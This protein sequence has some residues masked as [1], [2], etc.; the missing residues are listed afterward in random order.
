MSSQM[1]Y[2]PS[3]AK[4]TAAAVPR[5]QAKS[6]MLENAWIAVERACF[7]WTKVIIPRPSWQGLL[8]AWVY[9]YVCALNKST[10]KSSFQVPS[11][12]L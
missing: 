5:L 2:G 6:L 11:S 10:Q 3:G 9:Q 8:M 12:A 7:S 4:T 1:S